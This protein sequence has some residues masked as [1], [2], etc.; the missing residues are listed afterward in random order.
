MRALRYSL[1]TLVRNPAFSAVI[2]LLLAFGIGAN[3]LIFTAVDVLLLRDVPADHPEQLVRLQ[4]IH[5]NGFRTYQPT[6]PVTYRALL[7][8]RA[9]SVEDVFYST[10]DEISMEVGGRPQSVTFE[11]VSGN[12][13]S[14]LG[15]RP[16][17]GRLLGP[18]DDRRGTSYPV[19]L[20]YAFWRRAFNGRRDVIGE[21]VRLR[22]IPFTVVGVTPRGFNHLSVEGGPDIAI[23]NTAQYLWASGANA[24][25]DAQIFARLR[26]GV[27]VAQASAEV[28][29]LYP[30][31]IDATTPEFLSGTAIPEEQKQE[32]LRS[33]KSLR[34]FFDPV[35]HGTS[36]LLRKQFAVAVK[37]IM[38]AVGVLL[39]LVCANIAGLM[40]ARG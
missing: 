17:I 34:V 7:L 26:P 32:Y 30:G 35:S 12:Y 23:P 8:D 29:T 28:E 36:I 24:V 18:D 15:V 11:A 9:K 38:G 37:V 6:F 1:R 10:G 31:L 4:D 21:K 27:S 33:E 22:E 25:Y 14:A 2:I 3:T 16:L 39:L 20:S 5:P 40:L 13:Y 19:V